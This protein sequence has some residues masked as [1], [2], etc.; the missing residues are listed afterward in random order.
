MTRAALA[1]ALLLPAA[2]SCVYYNGMW[3]AQRLAREGAK[4]E[5]RGETV[6]ARQAWARAAVKAESVLAHHPRSGWA[7]D[8]LVLQGE[9]R[10]RSGACAE[11]VA[12]LDRALATVTAPPLHERAV[13]ARAEC[14]L[15][16]GEV[17]LAARVIEP[18]LASTDAGR[19]SRAEYLAGLAALAR[20]DRDGAGVLLGR[21]QEPAARVALVQALIAADRA[22]EVPAL[23]GRKLPGRLDEG[24]WLPV[25]DALAAAVGPESASVSVQRFV[26]AQSLSAG[27]RARLLLADGD[28]LLAARAT[29]AAGT[30]YSAAARLVPDSS[31]GQRARVRAVR[32]AA[33]AATGPANLAAVRQAL[34]RLT[35]TGLSGE[36][37]Q[38]ARVLQALLQQ[39]AGAE[40][41]SE[42]DRFRAAELARDSLRATHLAAALFESFA[43][44]TPTSL[45]A[46]KAIV[47]AL[48]LEPGAADSLL[49]VLD[50]AYPASPY[51]LALHG[52]NS[53]AYAAAEDSL[54]Q[55]LGVE[56]ADPGAADAALVAP[57]Q[58][59]PRGPALDP[60]PGAVPRG[61]AEGTRRPGVRR[62]GRP[63]DRPPQ[64]PPDR[65]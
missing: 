26:A 23:V 43:R 15:H 1:A 27:A 40:T 2:A 63:D 14:A 34:D 41:G 46:P 37:A 42:A 62:P 60:E 65:L 21:S 5:A 56:R 22:A 13:L 29:A 50:S 24:E 4:R 10:A 52:E 45:F 59:G 28:R 19:R 48:A 53:P 20:G 12:P 16:A 18:V 39:L 38:D 25:F 54:A 44:A 9:G 31:E 47:A 32:A 11:A 30:R 17:A 8:A 51:T 58:P 6:E 55:M 49:P 64:R 33:A 57:P 61:A 3:S 7:D 36:A 35:R